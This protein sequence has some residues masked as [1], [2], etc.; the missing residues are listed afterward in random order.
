MKIVGVCQCDSYSHIRHN[1][2]AARSLRGLLQTRPRAICAFCGHVCLSASIFHFASDLSP[3][4]PKGDGSTHQT[5][6][7]HL[8]V[9]AFYPSNFPYGSRIQIHT[10]DLTT[11]HY[12]H[13]A[14][15]H[16][17]LLPM[18]WALEEGKAVA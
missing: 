17:F 13:I 3:T 18:M 11:G 12:I 10:G 16:C 8:N 6:H 14:A 5:A 4:G 9:H 15:S 1:S 7:L 2:K